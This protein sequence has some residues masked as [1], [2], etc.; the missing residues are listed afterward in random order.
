MKI[1]RELIRYGAVGVLT[2]AVNFL[3]YVICTRYLFSSE[4]A[5]DEA[6]FATVFNWVA[7]AFAVLFAFFANR[8]FVFFES[9]RGTVLLLQLGSF[10]LLRLGSG[11]LE[12][13]TPSLLIRLGIND[14]FA[15]L[16]VA[17][18]V[19][20]VNYFFTKFVT[21]AKS[22]SASRRPDATESDG[23]LPL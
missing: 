3:V 22:G 5:L 1:F 2:T 4:F 13:F 6:L 21:F 11:V 9:R 8:C 10:V 23:N 17:L 16:T 20:L 18:A 19:I 12:N 7:W 14:L 15:K